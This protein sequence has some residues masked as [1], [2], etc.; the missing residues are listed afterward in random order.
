MRFTW[1]GILFI[2][3]LQLACKKANDWLNVPRTKQDVVFSTLKDYQALLNNTSILNAALPT[4]GLIGCD[5]LIVLDKNIQSLPVI[6]RNS[7]VWNKDIFEGRNSVEYSTSYLAINYA[8]VVLD[9][10]EKIGRSSSNYHEFNSIKGQAHFFRAIYYLE[11][12][13]LFCKPFYDQT[14]SEDKGLCLRKSPDINEIVKR[15]SL[16][17]TYK[18]ILEDARLSADLLTSANNVKTQPTK[19]AAYLLLARIYLNMSNFENAKKYTDSCL[20]LGNSLIDFNIVPRESLPYRFPDFKGGNDEIIFYAQ[21]NL[22]QT[23]Y[24][25]ENTAVSLVDTLLYRQYELTDLRRKVFYREFDSITI[26]F[27]GS[28]TGVASNFC[29]LATNEAYIIR[30]ECNARMGNL[31]DAIKDINDLL[32]KRYQRGTYVDFWSDNQDVVLRKVLLERRKELP[33]TGLIR[34]QDLRRLNLDPSLATSIFRYNKG[35]LIELK[36]NDSKYVYPIPQ[37]EINLAGIEQNIR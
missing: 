37:N 32:R 9:G 35:V 24:P 16:A 22:Y 7:Y 29:G 28:Y 1:F 33:F 2:V 27:K 20:L 18:L 14:A 19:K 21:G 31:P 15:S 11:L 36:P 26:K 12:A 17:E 25:S 23:I 30:A 5:N 10:I 34:W 6:E 13:S 4:I 8:N 3:I